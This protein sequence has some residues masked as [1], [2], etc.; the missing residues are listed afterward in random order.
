MVFHGFGLVSMVFQGGFM[1]FNGF[2]LV[3]LFF[4]V[5]SWFPWFFKVSRW[6]FIVIKDPRLVKSELSAEGAK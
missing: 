1:D 4:K 5:V 6:I 2:W 3:L